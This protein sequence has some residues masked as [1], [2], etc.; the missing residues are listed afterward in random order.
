VDTIEKAKLIAKL[1]V[2][3]SSIGILAGTASFVL[4]VSIAALFEGLFSLLKSTPLGMLGFLAVSV[5]TGILIQHRFTRSVDQAIVSPPSRKWL[6]AVRR[7][8]LYARESNILLAVM[9]VIGVTYPIT[10]FSAAQSIQTLVRDCKQDLDS[11]IQLYDDQQPPL[12]F[13]GPLCKCLSGVFLNK[14]GIV[15][16]ALFRSELLDTTAYRGVTEADEQA[17]LN[18]VLGGREQFLSMTQRMNGPQSGSP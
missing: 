17:C 2:P 1:R 11:Q 12:S 10:M 5:C 13:S 14:N 3:K 16:L 8:S 18:L 6:H 15:R 7:L 9:I 4:L